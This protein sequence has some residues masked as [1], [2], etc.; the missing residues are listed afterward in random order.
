ML[1]ETC[2]L[3]RQGVTGG[4]FDGLR[5]WRIVTNQLCGGER[6]RLDRDCYR[7]AELVQRTQRL[8]TGCSAEE[9]YWRRALALIVNIRPNLAQQY[10]DD[11]AS[12]YLIDLMPASLATD[13]RRLTDQLKARG[14]Y[15]NR[16][17]VLKA[18]RET[19]F[20]EQKKA[21]NCLTIV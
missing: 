6:S 16:M 19:V 17:T 21:R 3:S 1:R 18:C 15:H 20:A 13:S 2:V 12:E 10:S 4:Y 11:D 9:L 7:A 8:A 5:A 14:H